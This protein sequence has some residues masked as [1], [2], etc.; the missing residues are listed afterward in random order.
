[1]NNKILGLLENISRF[2]NPEDITTVR[3]EIGNL[4]LEAEKSIGNSKII[5]HENANQIERELKIAIDKKQ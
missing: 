4:R 1:M 2:K 3:V 5:L